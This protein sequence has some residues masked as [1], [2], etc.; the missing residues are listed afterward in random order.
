MP[1]AL[2][3][4][5]PIAPRLRTWLTPAPGSTFLFLFP[6]FS[7]M[8]CPS[9]HILGPDHSCKDLELPPFFLFSVHCS[10]RISS[11]PWHMAA[12][13]YKDSILV[14]FIDFYFFYFPLNVFLPIERSCIQFLVKYMRLLLLKN[15]IW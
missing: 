11:K 9:V 14:G 5:T 6:F 8:S 12:C 1:S 2:T 15:E 3:L 13:T 7:L 4:F 10:G